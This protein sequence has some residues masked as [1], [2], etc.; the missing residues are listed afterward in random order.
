MLELVLCYSN[1]LVNP[2]FFVNVKPL[3]QY[4]EGP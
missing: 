1:K 2:Q 3:F 4:K